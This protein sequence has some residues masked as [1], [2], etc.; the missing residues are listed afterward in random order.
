MSSRSRFSDDDGIRI[1]DVLDNLTVAEP[2]HQD[3][4]L[5]HGAYP[6]PEH[7]H[8]VTTQDALL[9]VKTHSESNVSVELGG[10]LLGKAFRAA[11][12]LFVRVEAA[13]P[14]ITDDNGPIHFTFTADAWTQIHVDRMAYPNL[15]IVGW[16]HTHPDLGVF[17]SA[18][19]EVVHAAAFTQPWH[20]GLV[21]DPVRDQASFFGWIDG[22]PRP[23]PGFYELI[24]ADAGEEGE[25]P[26][27]VVNW[28]VVIDDSWFMPPQTAGAA[29]H[30]IYND[31]IPP[32]AVYLPMAFSLL[33]LIVSAVALYFALR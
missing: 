5:L 12:R 9:Q 27:A 24:P 7:V 4:C 14:A 3:D 26:R 28:E 1:G 31:G 23:L 32:E 10:V 6:A 11:D 8:V 22:A 33:S 25:I 15:D 16:F 20:V 2:P 17:Y 13:I 21:V 19:D 29:P 30:I 18:D